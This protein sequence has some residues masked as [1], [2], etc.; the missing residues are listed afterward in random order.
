MWDTNWKGWNGDFRVWLYVWMTCWWSDR[1]TARGTGPKSP[2]PQ[3]EAEGRKEISWGMGWCSYF[4]PVYFTSILWITIKYT[5]LIWT[6]IT[7]LCWLSFLASGSMFDSNFVP[8]IISF[9]CHG[10]CGAHS[11]WNVL[12]VRDA[13]HE[14]YL[15]DTGR[16]SV[17]AI[18]QQK[19]GFTIPKRWFLTCFDP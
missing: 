3:V 11:A 1:T 18:S 10:T 8:E 15:C 16:F 5:E 6:Y 4:F 2:A 19:S 7:D 17:A 9:T 12:Q 14:K 13:T